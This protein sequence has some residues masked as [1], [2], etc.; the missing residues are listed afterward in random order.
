MSNYA[1][2]RERGV[3]PGIIPPA[4]GVTSF[5]TMQIAFLR[6][7]GIDPEYTVDDWCKTIDAYLTNRISY[8]AMRSAMGERRHHHTIN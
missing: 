8:D 3:I 2:H 7:L 6:G 4:D 5:A 1:T